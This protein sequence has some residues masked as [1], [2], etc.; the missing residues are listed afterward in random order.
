MTE[1]P[2]AEMSVI[3]DGEQRTLEVT[4]ETLESL[5]APLLARLREPVL[6]ALR[7]GGVGQA[8]LKEVVL[9]GGATRM[10]IVRRA[11][12][13]MFG[14]FPA[15]GV[16]P[17]HAVALG[18]GVQA[19]L[20]SRDA[21][22]KEVVLT[23]VCPYSLGVDTG[24]RGANGVLRQGI[25]SPIIERNTPVPAS[26]VKLFTTLQDGQRQ[27]V[28]GIF[29]GESRRVSDNINLG[30]V[31]VPV[32]PGRQGEVWV[33]CRFSYDINGL[34]EI[35]VHVP[36]TNER[37][38]LTIVDDDADPVDVEMRRHALSA[39]KV[40]P[41]DADENRTALARAERCYEESLGERREYIN[42]LIRAFEAALDTQDPRRADQERQV[43]ASALDGLEGATFL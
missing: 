32:P 40:H 27:V 11:A 34:I 28:F 42:Q 31:E 33:E 15:T 19:G 14:R 4:G 10:P 24:E 17:D 9:V 7:D 13:K 5:A 26:R 38:H 43:L 25:F 35:D 2:S 21:A 16:H 30:R 22:L 8:D 23:D 20:K 12:T 3:W 29:Q 39:L 1:A 36:S 6:R 41:R 18:A 37:R